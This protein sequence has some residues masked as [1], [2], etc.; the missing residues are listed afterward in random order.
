MN[1][2]ASIASLRL[3]ASALMLCLCARGQTSNVETVKAWTRTHVMG[4]PGGTLLDPTASIADGQRQAAAAASIAEAS[5]IVAA[6]ANGLTNALDRLWAVADA[7]NNFSGRLY[8]AADLD[9]DPDYEN[10]Q[11]FVVGEQ[12]TGTSMHYFV[13]YT[14]VLAK[15]PKTLWALEA[16]PGVTHWSPGSIDTNAPLTNVLGYACYD[17]AVQRPEAAGNIILRCNKYLRWGTPDTP[18]DIPDDGL[19]LICGGST[20]RPFTGSV[21][22]TNGQLETVRTFLSGFL[23]TVATNEVPQ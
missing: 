5:N 10:L 22:V 13:H 1:R 12:N 4:V 15:P 17:I 9:P 18:F 2:Y 11:A 20:N 14:R 6:A 23:Y 7:T 3:C 8:I 19:E 21:S 16:A